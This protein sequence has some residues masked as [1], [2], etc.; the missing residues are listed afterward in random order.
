MN[1]ERTPQSFKSYSQQGIGTQGVEV[2]GQSP[3]SQRMQNPL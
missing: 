3:L 2:A 1:I